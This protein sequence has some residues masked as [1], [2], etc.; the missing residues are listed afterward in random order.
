MNPPFI[1]EPRPFQT[2][3]EA[4][5]KRAHYLSPT[6]MDLIPNVYT[7]LCRAGRLTVYVKTPR[8][9]DTLLR[10]LKGEGR[11]VQQIGTHD[12]GDP[13]YRACYP[14]GFKESVTYP[15]GDLFV[16][17]TIVVRCWFAP[18]MECTPAMYQ[19]ACHIAGF[20]SDPSFYRQADQENCQ[21]ISEPMLEAL[22]KFLFYFT[23]FTEE[24][25]MAFPPFFIQ[26][27]DHNNMLA[28]ASFLKAFRQYC[29]TL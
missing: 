18:D 28:A 24:H 16:P 26:V 3:E 9:R 11:T 25:W 6:E 27:N 2:P 19:H 8:G 17:E 21:E 20:I 14:Q 10:L 1:A 15:G 29:T 22:C 23:A 13:E 12:N 5:S 7:F 4:I